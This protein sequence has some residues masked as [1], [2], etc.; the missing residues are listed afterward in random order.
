MATVVTTNLMPLT[1]PRTTEQPVHIRN[2][3]H[4]RPFPQAADLEMANRL[5][6]HLRGPACA[7]APRLI[8]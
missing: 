5:A 4:S 2:H 7:P 1:S 3:A 6:A 8:H